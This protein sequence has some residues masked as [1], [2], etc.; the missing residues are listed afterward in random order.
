MKYLEYGSLLNRFVESETNPENAPVVL[1][2]VS[3][4]KSSVIIPLINK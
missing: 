3:I 4:H 2:L 1:W